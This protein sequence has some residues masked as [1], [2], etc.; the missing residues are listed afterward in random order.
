MR[1]TA[2]TLESF[3]KRTLLSRTG[4][5]FL[6]IG[7]L[8]SKRTTI[9]EIICALL[10]IL[11][12]YTGL[13][14]LIDYEK[15]KFSI[16]RSPFIEKM[17]EYIA[18]TL[19]IGEILISIALIVKRTRLIGLYFSFILMA[20]FTGYIWLMLTY[21]SDLPCSC[22][23]ILATMSWKDHLIFNAAFTFLAITGILLQNK[24]NQI[25]KHS[26]HT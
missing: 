11:F 6:K 7:R 4:N 23:G 18:I 1:K 9:V 22:G 26:Y 24:L 12:I 13:N 19:P 3:P 14:K 8:L 15:F 17:Q 2:V 5:I 16:G 10:I 21:A 20:L 25:N